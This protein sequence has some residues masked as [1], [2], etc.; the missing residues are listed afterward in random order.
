MNVF[1]LRAFVAAASLSLCAAGAACTQGSPPS[2]GAPPAVSPAPAATPAARAPRRDRNRLTREDLAA[3]TE[4][5]LLALLQGAR[6]AWLRA[7]GQVSITQGAE[8]VWVYRDGIR[9]GGI[10]VLE[11][12]RPGEVREIEFLPSHEATQRYGL[13]HGAG[14]ILV[15][16]L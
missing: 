16:S 14:A 8:Q 1:S 9:M 3:R 5:D 4:S 12:M 10:Q 13:D 6:P 15:T 7:R 2:G 11:Q